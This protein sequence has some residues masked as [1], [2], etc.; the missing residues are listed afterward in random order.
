[1]IIEL[2]LKYM[3]VSCFQ[4]GISSSSSLAYLSSFEKRALIFIICTG[5]RRRK[6]VAARCTQEHEKIYDF[7]LEYFR[8]LLS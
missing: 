6:I 8:S 7:I 4:G 2:F 1:M 3:L 5:A